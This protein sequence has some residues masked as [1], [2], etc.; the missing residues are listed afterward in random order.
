MFPPITIER[1][2]ALVK[3]EG[4]K[5]IIGD[6]GE[7]GIGFDELSIWFNCSDKWFRPYA[8]WRYRPTTKEQLDKA[9]T[10]A[11]ELNRSLLMPKVI[12]P[13]ST[14]TVNVPIVLEAAL[15]AE[16]GYSDDQMA[17]TFQAVMSSFFNA[18]A[19]LKEKLPELTPKE[20]A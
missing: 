1:L 3:A 9:V 14:E 19:A 11:N 15:P 10:T 13:Q 5:Y 6:D 20:E 16:V 12:V 4:L 17:A 7:L 18:A 8:Y 2:E